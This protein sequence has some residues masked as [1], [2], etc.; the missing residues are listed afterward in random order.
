MELIEN[1]WGR[2]RCSH[3]DSVMDKITKD[4][5][6]DSED[7][8]H[9]IICPVCGTKIWFDDVYLS[10]HI[11]ENAMTPGGIPHR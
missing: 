11:V 3:C 5:I 8:G 9:Y 2:V 4:D 6:Y 1:N 7:D 10:H